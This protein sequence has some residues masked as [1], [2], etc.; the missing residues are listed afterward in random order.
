MLVTEL[1]VIPLIASTRE[2]T[3]AK[4]V[5]KWR[6]TSEFQ[7]SNFEVFSPKCEV[8]LLKGKMFSINNKGRNYQ[9]GFHFQAIC[10]IKWKNL[11]RI[12]LSPKLG[13]DTHQNFTF[14]RE[15]FKVWHL[16]LRRLTPFENMFC[17]HA[18][19]G[20]CN[21]RY[22]AQFEKKSSLQFQIMVSNFKSAFSCAAWSS[23]FEITPPIT[24]WIALT[25]V[26]QLLPVL[27]M[28]LYQ[29]KACW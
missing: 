26:Q 27:N 11:R 6:Q 25:L 24:P 1:C 8:T 14:G 10:K 5:F 23:D 12:I 13:E 16:K 22:T 21:Q 15:N 7:M 29:N 20:R 2:R 19:T 3:L 4:H 17:E 18:F 28:K 9:K